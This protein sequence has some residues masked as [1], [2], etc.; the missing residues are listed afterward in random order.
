MEIFKRDQIADLRVDYSLKQFD[1]ADLNA[2]PLLQFETW[3]Q[4]AIAANVNEPNAMTLATIKEDGSPA[5]RIVLLK[6]LQPEGFTFFT[7]YD[8]HKGIE[9]QGNTAVALVFCW[10]ELQ[11]QVRIEGSVTRL[12]AQESDSYFAVRPRKSQIGAHASKQST[13]LKN[14]A[15]LEENFTKCEAAFLN[16]TVPRP[17]N[18]GGYIVKPNLIE[19]W[20]GRQSRLHDRFMYIKTEN[21]WSISRLAP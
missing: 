20:Q 17:E 12:S 4:E 3:F 9:M 21:N 14:R 6:G 18:W 5:A 19:F 11:R 15:E 16:T 8:S 13:I 2:D 7:N 10:L 1:V